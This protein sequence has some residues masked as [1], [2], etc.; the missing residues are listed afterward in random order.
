MNLP[1]ALLVLALS[2]PGLAWGAA[3]DSPERIARL[4]YVEGQI[5]FRAEHE[6][7]SY[8][9]PDR[10]L[11]PGDRIATEP[12]GRAE[13]ALGSA[14]VRLDERSE[15]V[16]S[17]LDAKTVRIVLNQGTANLHLR[18]LYD[19]E[20]FAVATPNTTLT[21]NEPG[22]YRITVPS[23]STTDLTVRGGSADGITAGGPVRVV[24]GQRVRFEGSQALASLVPPR[25]NDA[26]DDWVLD[27]EV[28]LG[29]QAPTT[30]QLATGDE[31]REL[32]RYGE[33]YDDSSYGRV[34]MPAYAYGGHDPFRYGYW[35]T[36][37]GGRA[38]VSSMPWYYYTYYSGRWTY[39]DRLNRWGWVP[40]RH[41]HDRP[42]VNNPPPVGIPLG[43]GRPRD[44]AGK[45]QPQAMTPRRLGTPESQAPTWRESASIKPS[46]GSTPAPRVNREQPAPQPS[47]SPPRSSGSGTPTM[48]PSQ[49][50]S[51]RREATS[52]PA[53]TTNRE[54][55]K[56]RPD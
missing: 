34:W 13:L 19:D 55:G 56:I 15:L 12:A 50:S 25:A 17:T 52:S 53:P 11:I 46:Q 8:A 43:N 27:R 35:D 41:R 38:W 28:E 32:D 3:P 33:W 42:V 2:A 45:G 54:L 39:F 23:E 7:A 6:V 48:R 1:K 37:G 5:K 16:I 22:E 10:P 26:F 29:E 9:L 31:Y 18:E 21:L 49:P 20:T 14:T 40:S 30:E 51:T 47:A 44:G 24:E 36:Y 4:G